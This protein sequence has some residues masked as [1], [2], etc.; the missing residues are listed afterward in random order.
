VAQVGQAKVLNF[1][2]FNIDVVAAVLVGG[3]AIQGGEGSTLRTAL[4]A[5]VIALLT[6][7][8]L[9]SQFEYGTRLVITGVVV[10]AAVIAFNW[11][12]SRSSS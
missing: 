12:R 4:G 9:L 1:E 2:G 8:M 7:Y 6:N 10:G 11:V 5:I 3:T